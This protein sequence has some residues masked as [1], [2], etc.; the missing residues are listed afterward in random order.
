[1]SHG[2]SSPA[3]PDRWRAVH[4]P[5][6]AAETYAPGEAMASLRL[7]FGPQTIVIGGLEV[8]NFG[9]SRT[10]EEV[11]AAAAARSPIGAV[12]VSLDRSRKAQTM[13]GLGGN[14]CQP[15]YGSTEPMDAVGRFNLD[16]LK[17]AHARVGIPLNWWAPEPG[18]YKDEA[19][20]HA[21]FL[22]MQDLSRRRIPIVGSVW[23]GPAWMLGGSREQMG[24]TLPPDKYDACIE[25][26][27]RYLTTA[28]DTYGVTV[29]HFSF[30][31]ADLGVNF[32]FTSA[33]IAAFIR[34]A[35]PR[36]KALGLKTKL[37]VGDTANGAATVRYCRP[38]LTDRELAPY[39]GPI[40]F[41]CWDALSAPDAQYAGIAALGKEFGKPVWCLEAGH[42]AQLWQQPN[43]WESW[44]NA[45]RTA[46]AY[47]RTI[48]L[49]GATIMDYWTYQDNYPL[50]S[51]DGKKG[52]PV[53]HVMAQMESVF[54]PGATVVAARADNEDVRAI[55][56]VG[57][58][59]GQA[60]VLIVN[61]SGPGTVTV[62]GFASRGVAPASRRQTVRIETST[63]SGQRRSVT[64]PV[65]PGGAVRVD[66]PARSVVT[67]VQAE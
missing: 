7:A 57:P 52:F 19:Q 46:L 54:A 65:G 59:S 33:Q 61:Q 6:Q 64:A 18:V 9:K 51:R 11:V 36:F 38:L 23:E 39:L 62:S 55:G 29:E 4:V 37:L 15:R 12:R 41:H 1:V 20:A 31:E 22:L 25:A 48:R 8:R 45:L 14:F 60:G 2:V 53:F 43:P 5:F 17:V 67:V 40:A 58:G 13:V 26:I 49:T 47:E 35:G 42:D 63:S 32:K 27:A 56:V 10:L 24:R 66:V 34:R 3:Q 50:V 28:R 44:E 30:N 16:R 21:S